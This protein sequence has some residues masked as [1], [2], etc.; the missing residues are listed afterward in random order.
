MKCAI[1]A[2]GLGTR[3]R[4]IIGDTPKPM[5]PLAGV[6]LLERLIGLC[7][8]FEIAEIHLL[9]SYRPEAIREHFGDGSKFGVRLTYWIDEPPLGAAGSMAPALK[10]LGEDILVLYG[11]VFAEMD[12]ARLI[13]FHQKHPEAAAT[14]VVHP[15]DHP[16]DSDLATV[17]GDRVT[18]FARAPHAAGAW[19]ANLVNAG[20]QIVTPRLL[21]YIPEGRASDFGADVFP[22]A[23][24]AGEFLVAYHTAEYIKDIGAP[25]RYREVERDIL[26]DKPRRFSLA[27]ARRAVFVDCDGTLN[28]LVPLL[29]RLEDL[30]LYPGSAA[31]VRAVN[32]SGYLAIAV[33]NRPQIARGLVTVTQVQCLHNKLETLLGYERAKLD[34]IYY[35]PHHPDGGYAG[36]A[37]E[38]KIPCRCRKPDTLLY[39]QAARRFHIDLDG[40]A[41]VGDSARDIEAARRL[42][43]R[44]V[45]VE[46]GLAGRDLAAGM[47]PDFVA[48]D[49]LHAVAWITGQPL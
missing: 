33:T 37:P 45:L 30:E 4:P 41:V 22:A 39:E 46:T 44:A 11:D 42:G 14:L 5:A 21:P 10:A 26:T 34:A 28:V 24:D 35:C 43:C 18:G 12:L 6:P 38:Y 16:H 19:R 17:E 27:N 20:V 29:R 49:L 13:D 2:G 31:A 8:R 48:R 40:S 1:I 9:L 36:E 7:R 32:E 3:L 15:N 23:A 25:E 47:Q